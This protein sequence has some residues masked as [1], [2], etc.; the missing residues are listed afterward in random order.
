M[1]N[2]IMKNLFLTGAVGCGKSTSLTTALGEN[3][4]KAGGFL[5]VRQRDEAGKPVAF[6]LTRPD[7]SERKQI[8]DLSDKSNPMRLEVFSDFGVRLLDEARNCESVI[9]DEIGGFEMLSDSFMDALMHLLESETPIIG[10][11]KGEEPAG[12][13]IQ[14]L[15]LGDHY[16]QKAELLRQWL[17]QDK[18]T[19]LYECGQF[20]PEG[21]RLAIGWVSE[22]IKDKKTASIS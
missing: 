20:D 2:K 11:M 4:A 8:L 19:L 13:M 15:G 18:N 5:T 21:L 16:V 7:G 9:L 3:L 22:H 17:R 10:V 1:Q 6:W 14:K 12:K